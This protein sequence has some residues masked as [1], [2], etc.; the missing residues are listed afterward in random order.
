MQTQQHRANTKSPLKHGEVSVEG[1]LTKWGEWKQFCFTRL[2]QESRAHRL[3]VRSKQYLNHKAIQTPTW[4]H[5]PTSQPSSDVTYEFIH[6][7]V[8]FAILMY[9][10]S[11]QCWKKQHHQ[12]LWKLLCFYCTNTLYEPRCHRW[13]QFHII[14]W[15]LLWCE[16]A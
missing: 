9:C 10:A 15:V 6:R 14:A 3:Q 7:D 5:Y 2:S 1:K 4:P 11:R 13:Q 8:R 16:S 12:K